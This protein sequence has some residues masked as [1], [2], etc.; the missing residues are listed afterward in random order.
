MSTLRGRIAIF[1]GAVAAMT[2]M[3]GCAFIYPGATAAGWLVGFV[4]WAQILVGNLSLMMIHRLTL[5]RWGEIIAPVVEPAALVIPLLVLFAV[6]IFVAI[7]ALYPWAQHT[8]SLKPDILSL[9]LNRPAF[10]VRSLV[11]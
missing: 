11:A 10:V 5:G 6:P 3:V 9:Y 4:F 7:P 2:A 8:P 1:V